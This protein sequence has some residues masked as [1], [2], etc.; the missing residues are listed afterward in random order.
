MPILCPQGRGGATNSRRIPMRNR[1][2]C[3]TL[4]MLMLLTVLLTGCNQ[5]KDTADVEQISGITLTMWVITDKEVANTDEEMAELKAKLLAQYGEGDAYNKAVA[6]A[7]AT[8]A[9]YEKV[10]AEITKITKSKFKVNLDLYY[11]TEDQYYGTK[12]FDREKYDDLKMSASDEEIAKYLEECGKLTEVMILNEEYILLKEKAAKALK[13]YLKDAKAEESFQF[14]RNGYFAVDKDS[15]EG[16]LI[17]NRTVQLN[18]SYK[19]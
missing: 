6:E 18:S 13:K 5:D 10:E 17:F 15:T 2:I 3:L 16:N 14:V 4:S 1:F 11:Y 7:E 12:E 9:A 19:K 8:K